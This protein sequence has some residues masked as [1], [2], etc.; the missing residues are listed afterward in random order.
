[1]WKTTFLDNLWIE[2]IDEPFEN[3]VKGKHIV[4]HIEER[5]RVRAVDYV[6]KEGTKTTVDISNIEDAL[7][8]KNVNLGLDTFVDQAT[9]RKVKG[10]IREVYADKG[11]N[12]VRITT[13]TKPMPTGPKFVH[14]SFI[15]D[16]GPKYKLQDIIFE[17][18]AA[19]TD[20]QLRSQMKENKPKAWWSFFTSGGTYMEAKFEE[21]A[22][23]V[24]EFYKNNGYV[25]AVVGQPKI[26]TVK[27]SR[28]G[29]TRYIRLRLPVDEGQRYKIGTFTISDN[30][31]IKTE[32]LR[33]FFKLAEGDYYDHEKVKKGIEKIQELYGQLGFWQFTPEPMAKPRGIDPETGQAVGPEPPPAIVD[34][35]IRMNEGKQYFVN[36]ITLLGNTTTHDSV[37]RRELRVLEGSVFDTAALKESIRRLNQ[38]GYFK[39]LEGRDDEVS[40]EPTPGREGLVDIKL[41]FQEQNRNQISFGAGVSQYDGF[42]GQL[43]YQT[44]NFLGRGETFG[45][46]LQRGSR[47]Q[48]YQVSFSEP[49]L[50]DRPI[51]AGIEGYSRTFVYPYQFSQGSTGGTLIFGFPLA[52]NLR[53]FTS[54][55]YERVR[56]Y[57][58]NEIYLDAAAL[59][60]NP[61]LRESLLIDTG[62]S[63]TVSKVTPQVV[64][65]TVNQPLFPTAGRR[66]SAAVELA[67]LGGNTEFTKARL[68]GIFYFPLSGP[69][70]RFNL[71]LRAEGQWIAPRGVVPLPIFEKFFLGGEYSVRGFDMRS[72]GPRDP[73]TGVVTGGNKTLTFNAEFYIT[74]AGPV[75]LLA[76]YDAGQVKDVGEHFAWWEPITETV[77]PPP[78]LLFDPFATVRLTNEPYVETINVIGKAPAF[79]TSTGLE[80]RFF[81]PVLNVPFRLIAA[82]NPSRRGVFNNNLELTKQFTFRFAVGT[83]F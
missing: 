6:A 25:R 79:K 73:F 61:Y 58:I 70:G 47:A 31:A 32:P 74:I 76:F 41:K 20:A 7:R 1:M 40:V 17:G 48:Q 11:Y 54:Y 82:W 63:R 46:N 35:N 80:L 59:A 78:P 52:R 71:G 57:D 3:G 49:Y 5:A 69:Q 36:R 26:E 45:V 14:V 64:F 2:V 9:I 4:F 55:G 12:D 29:N 22:F 50:F 53:M 30:T 34:V 60:S 39:P 81:M 27:D 43:S 18:N 13:E 68:E 42:F 44:S 67:G 37:A 51:T 56:V 21:D 33:S 62:G 15:I 72:I 83:T 65:N 8:D 38:L 75:R 10:V 28:D 23:Q 24:E 66:L 77:S 16:Q 19:Y